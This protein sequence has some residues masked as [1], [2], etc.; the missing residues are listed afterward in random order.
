MRKVCFAQTQLSV[1]V[2]ITFQSRYQSKWWQFAFFD[3]TVQLISVLTKA[4]APSGRTN[5]TPCFQGS[6]LLFVWLMWRCRKHQCELNKSVVLLSFVFVCARLQT[7][8]WVS[9]P[10]CLYCVERVYRYIRS[11]DPVTIVT[12]I[13][14]PCDVIELRMLKKNFKARPG[15]VF[16][17]I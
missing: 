5:M 14:H 6:C 15:Q 13:R 3:H 17:R 7:W 1:M 10:L 2:L 11:C 16:M 4:V 8:L 12:V 9:G